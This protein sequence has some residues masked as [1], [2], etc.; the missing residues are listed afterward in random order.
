MIGHDRPPSWAPR[1]KRL[2]GLALA[3]LTLSAPTSSSAQPEIRPVP[4][5]RADVRA[6]SVAL[7]D[8]NGAQVGDVMYFDGHQRMLVSLTVKGQGIVLSTRVAL[9]DSGGAIPGLRGQIEESLPFEG[10]DCS[11]TPFI[12]YAGD[13][14][15]P[16]TTITGPGMT[17]WIPDTSAAPR[18]ITE[19]SNLT[20]SGTCVPQPFPGI[21]M[22]QPAEA[23]VD[24]A[25]VFRLPFRLNFVPQ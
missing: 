24:L 9:V 6:A 1:T 5:G 4:G 20:V 8:A 14:L 25:T 23:V 22:A 2:L 21:W 17:L 12:R 13:E 11:G 3:A 19:R 15:Y 7:V 10:L 16:R 18:A